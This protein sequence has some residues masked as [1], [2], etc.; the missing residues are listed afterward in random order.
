MPKM[1]RAFGVLHDELGLL[2]AITLF[3]FVAIVWHAASAARTQLIPAEH[4]TWVDTSDGLS[5]CY[6]ND[7]TASYLGCV[8]R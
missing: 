7:L 4:V 2:V 5:R 6:Y 3:V 1:P 8:R